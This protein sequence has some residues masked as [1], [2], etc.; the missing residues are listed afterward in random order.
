MHTRITL[1]IVCAGLFA[2][3][4]CTKSADCPE[5]EVKAEDPV[6]RGQFMVTVGGCNDCHTPK[7]MTP[8]G[9]VPDMSRML[10]GHPSGEPVAPYD[11]NTVGPWVLLSPG[12]TC[13][14]GPWGT[15]FAA[16][17]TP[18]E[19]GIGSWSE[20]QFVKALQEGKH[21]GM[22]N[23]RPIMPPMPWQEIGK[24]DVNDLKAIYAYLKSIPPVDN[25]VPAYMPPVQ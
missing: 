8:Q 6:Q 5:P 2:L 11:K 23:T 14:V 9:P 24:F 20:E 13:A 1:T 15:S 3:S 17:L 12:L 22:D 19:S 7:N 4:A 16:N 21:M 10:S 18:S 25:V